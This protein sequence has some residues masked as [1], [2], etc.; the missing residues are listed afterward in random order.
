MEPATGSL[1]P[2][3]QHPLEGDFHGLA[4][5]TGHRPW[6]LP[7]GPWIMTQT[8]HHLLFAHWPVPAEALRPLVPQRL[9]LDTR[10]G[11]AWVSIVPFEIANAT[12]RGL[13]P[14]PFASA[15]PEL[16]VRTYVRYRDKPG[17]YFFSLDA[18]SVVAVTGARLLYLL[19][20]YYARITTHHADRATLFTSSRRHHAAP[21][22]E[23]AGTYLPA[24]EPFLA[25]PG[26]LDDW[27]TSRYC[28]YTAGRDGRLHRAEIHHLPWLLQAAEAEI[29]VNTMPPPGLELPPERP[30]LHY[31][32]RL[33]VLFWSLEDAE[34]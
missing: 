23:F 25:S 12:V 26:S 19:P 27:L 24:S 18:G 3:P 14:L 31:A 8:W 16:N 22:A 21:P 15:F 32:H 5:K 28:L 9:T 29:D 4:R 34:A 17:V 20:Y 7:A 10:E 30:L 11:S 1:V 6:P 2:Q 33:D 13:L